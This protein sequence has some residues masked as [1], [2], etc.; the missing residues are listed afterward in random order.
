MAVTPTNKNDRAIAVSGFCF[1][2]QAQNFTGNSELRLLVG[3]LD[4]YTYGHEPTVYKKRE[5][6]CASCKFLRIWILFYLLQLKVVRRAS[7]LHHNIAMVVKCW[8]QC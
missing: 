4:E 7:Q 6:P 1:F 5:R 3:K 8:L 2:F